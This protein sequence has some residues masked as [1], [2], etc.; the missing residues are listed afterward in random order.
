MAVD[1]DKAVKR[2]ILL[3]GGMDSIALCCWQR[4]DLALTI[5]YGQASAPG[6]IRASVRVAE[7]L[8]IN[9]EVISV[10]CS[11]LGSGDLLNLPPDPLAPAVEW[12]PFRN[13]MLVTFAAMRAIAR[14]MEGIMVGSVASDGFHRDGT[15]GF[16]RHLDNVVSYQ[17]G[18]LRVTAPAIHFTSAQLIILSKIEP[19][20]LAWAHSCHRSPFACG[21]CRGCAKHLAVLEELGYEA[22]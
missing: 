10:D 17:E 8:K 6:E 5:D 3:S 9:H 7:E 20:L 13:Q 4:P 21:Q 14:G 15:E 18:K 1:R 19:S 16:Y 11:D 2:A 12:W 22:Y